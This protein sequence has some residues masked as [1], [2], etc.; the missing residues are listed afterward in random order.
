MWVCGLADCLSGV[1]TEYRRLA[2]DDFETSR[3][4]Y[5]NFRLFDY[6]EVKQRVLQ[7]F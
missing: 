2:I 6:V 3:G 4:N 5:R 7:Q 1:E